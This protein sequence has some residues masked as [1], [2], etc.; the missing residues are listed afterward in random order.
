MTN[1]LTEVEKIV[2]DIASH[3]GWPPGSGKQKFDEA[4][5]YQIEL[6]ELLRK[7]IEAVRKEGA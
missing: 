7:L 4:V 2:D 1:D 5:Q 3:Y 6:R